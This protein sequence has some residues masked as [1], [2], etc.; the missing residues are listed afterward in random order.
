VKKRWLYYLFSA[1][2]CLAFFSLGR[3]QLS[4]AE[5]KQQRLDTVATILKERKPE[6]FSQLSKQKGA[7]L[8]WVSG[9]GHFL[10][11]PAL[12]LDNQRLGDKVGINV[13][14]VF[15]PDGGVAVLV[16]LGW[17]VVPGDRTMP[18]PEKISGSYQLSGLFTAP[19]SPG[20]AIGPAYVKS[21]EDYWLLTRMPLDELS[22]DLKIPL[23][24]RVLRLNPEL[25]MGY[26]RDLDILPNT[27]PPEKHK[28]YAVQWF[29]MCLA[30]IIIT[31][32]L[33]MRKK[34]EKTKENKND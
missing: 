11:T 17:L 29:G 16:N 13:Y 19:P 12:F 2:L 26:A 34:K 5:W 32:V 27:L 33:S 15:Q 31:L 18:V 30:T 21:N 22:A 20:I 14:R 7:D 6:S 8:A 1:L 3:W 10:T 9:R 25:S 24:T 23:A 28:G 4:R